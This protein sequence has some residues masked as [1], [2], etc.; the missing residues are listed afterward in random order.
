[1]GFYHMSTNL[2]V[3]HRCRFFKKVLKKE[4]VFWQ[5]SNVYMF[6]V[7]LHGGGGIRDSFKDWWKFIEIIFSS[8]GNWF[9]SLFSQW[10]LILRGIPSIGN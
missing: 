1:M 10:E 7:W 2:G 6:L 5:M 8:L 4:R 9:T 3:Q